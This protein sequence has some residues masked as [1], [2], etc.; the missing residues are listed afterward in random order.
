MQRLR[1]IALAPIGQAQ[2]VAELGRFVLDL[3]QSACA[4]D[5]AV[6]QRDQK[7]RVARRLVRAGNETLGIRLAVRMRSARR[8]FGYAAVIGERCYRFWGLE[9][10]G[11]EG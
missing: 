10:W 8:V 1:R 6:A 11:A 5:G 9:W 3:R 7:H 2:P 4:H